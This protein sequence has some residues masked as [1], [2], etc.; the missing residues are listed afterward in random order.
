M[1]GSPNAVKTAFSIIIDELPHFVHHV[2]KW[3]N[4]IHHYFFLFLI[5]KFIN[6]N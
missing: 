5:K 6:T 3:W 4:N 1:P 2:K